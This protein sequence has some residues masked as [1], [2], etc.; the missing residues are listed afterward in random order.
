M[1]NLLSTFMVL[2]VLQFCETRMF[3]RTINK[4]FQLSKKTRQFITTNKTKI[5][6]K[7]MNIWDFDHPVIND[8]YLKYKFNEP[9]YNLLKRNNFAIIKPKHINYIIDH[10]DLL[11][12]HTYDSSDEEK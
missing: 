4:L 11:S 7:C 12:D 1:E 2:S 6:K 8:I 9:F 3:D 10:N 5:I